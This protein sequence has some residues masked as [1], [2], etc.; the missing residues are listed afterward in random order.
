M[1]Q[2]IE[3]KME[4]PV[5][6]KADPKAVLWVVAALIVAALIGSN[7]NSSPYPE[8]CDFVPDPRGGYVDC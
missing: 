7:Q 3:T 4:S 8:N 6:G 1:L 2:R 5:R